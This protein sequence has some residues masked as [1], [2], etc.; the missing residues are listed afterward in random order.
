MSVIFKFGLDQLRKQSPSKTRTYDNGFSLN[1]ANGATV[2]LIHGLTG[3]P[4]EM[5]FLANYLN[6]KGYTV[7]EYE[8]DFSTVE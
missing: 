6:K 2:I 4:N 5:R 7:Q 3:T 8:K 1:G